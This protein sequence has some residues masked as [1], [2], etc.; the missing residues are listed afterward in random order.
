MHDGT[1]IDVRDRTPLLRLLVVAALITGLVAM[2]HLVIA[3]HHGGSAHE[4]GAHGAPVVS[5]GGALSEPAAVGIPEVAAVP[6]AL[7]ESTPAQDSPGGAVA[8]CLAVIGLVLLALPHLL[9]R[10][11]RRS[12]DAQSAALPRVVIRRPRAPDLIRLSVCRT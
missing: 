2:H 3:C 4:S 1:V 11:A 6:P 9:G 5:P 8:V 7:A 12:K 10:I